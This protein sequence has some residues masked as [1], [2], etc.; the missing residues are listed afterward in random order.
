MRPARTEEKIDL[1]NGLF[2]SFHPAGHILGAA[3]V[4]LE[5]DGKHL[6]FSGDVGRPHDLIM[7]PPAA[8]QRADWLVIESTYGNRSHDP[9]DPRI[10]LGSVIRRT[11]AHG[12][13]I[14]IP[15]F[16]VGRAQ[17][18]LFLISE[19]MHSG[20]IP[21][22]PV[23]LDSPMAVDATEIFCNHAGEHRLSISQCQKLAHSA[24]LIRNVEESKALNARKGPMIILAASGMAT[25]GRVLHH[26]K[27]RAPDSRNTILFSGYQAGGTRGAALL[28]GA[29]TIKIHGEFIPVRAQVDCISNL[30][31]HADAREI[32][33]WLGAFHAPPQKTFIVHG[34]PDAADAL[35]QQIE[36][37]LKW[38][39]CLPDYLEK[40]DLA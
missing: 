33:D 22:L 21:P 36:N 16:A 19:L 9:E 17:S 1:G 20:E 5:V 29:A 18:L 34:E 32:M 2:L 3:M 10:R 37:Q 4:D 6:L 12:G 24:H 14:L 38:S 27:T 28:A 13:V 39:V 26:L 15:T 31:A 40:I 30:S 11:A 7:N 35:R 23:Y 8:I 25:G